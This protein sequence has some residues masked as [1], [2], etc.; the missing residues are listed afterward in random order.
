VLLGASVKAS[1]REG[2]RETQHHN[3]DRKGR[4]SAVFSR[5]CPSAAGSLPSTV[6]LTWPEERQAYLLALFIAGLGLP[7]TVVTLHTTTL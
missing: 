3:A 4:Q 5:E 1:Q 2:K 6:E 7:T